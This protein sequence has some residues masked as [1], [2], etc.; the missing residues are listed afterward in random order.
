MLHPPSPSPARERAQQ[1]GQHVQ[2]KE[3]KGEDQQRD[4]TYTAFHLGN[5]T[6]IQSK[7]D[8]CTDVAAA[9]SGARSEM[10]K[11][12]TKMR[13]TISAQGIRM[14]HRTIR[15]RL[16]LL[17]VSGR[18]RQ[19]PWRCSCTRLLATA[20]AEFKRLKGGDARH[21]QQQLIG[22]QTIPLVPQKPLNG[23]LPQN[24]GGA[25]SRSA[26][27]LG[28][29]MRPVGEEGGAAMH[30]EC[31]DILDTDDDCVANVNRS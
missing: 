8:G 3:E 2:A 29:I 10:G 16:T 4:P 15:P 7:G 19:R 22:E 12:G 18:R 11:N 31:E 30:F 1:G 17:L 25:R 9:R 24:F 27:K 20:P 6:T 5:A 23:Q 28:S 26:P 14:V 13:L 21:R